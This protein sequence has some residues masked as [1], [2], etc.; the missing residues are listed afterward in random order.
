[1]TLDL[2][3]SFIFEFFHAWFN[4]DVF[5]EMMI[6]ESGLKYREEKWLP[7]VIEI[8]MNDRKNMWEEIN[9]QRNLY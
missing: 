7:T 5:N 6:T 9:D 3:L 4:D 1:M 8:M 2:L